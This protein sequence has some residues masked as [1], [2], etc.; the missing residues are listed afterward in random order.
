[1]QSINELETQLS[2]VDNIKIQL[3]DISE[4]FKIAIE[5][6]DNSA[7][8]EYFEELVNISKKIESEI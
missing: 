2:L 6:N 7:L 1:M 3:D 5:E 4:F 8:E